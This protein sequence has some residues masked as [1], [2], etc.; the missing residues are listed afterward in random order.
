MKGSDWQHHNY[1]GG[2]IVHTCNV[3]LNA[4]MLAEFYKEKVSIDLVKFCAL[5]RDVGKLFDYKE[6]E[7]FSCENE[8]SMNRALLGHGF[9]GAYYVA[10]KLKCAYSSE[11]LSVPED[12]VHDVLVQVS[13][14][15]GAHMDCFGACAPQQM[16]EVLIIGC[17]DKVDAY[18][19]QTIIAENEDSFTVG[20][21]D[22]FYRAVVDNSK[23][24]PIG[25]DPL[26]VEHSV[27]SHAIDS[28]FSSSGRCRK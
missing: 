3:T 22:V 1:A 19:D 5:M 17:A 4:I 16:F 25:I 14:C 20:T 10:N 24:M 8:V 7:T 13:H 28:E 2:L 15:I 26:Q 27:Y 9:E 6:Q 18:L 21:G 23:V 11:N 12:Y